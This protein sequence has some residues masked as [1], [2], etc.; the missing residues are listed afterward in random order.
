MANRLTYAD[1]GVDID[2]ANQL[3]DTIKKIAKK[4]RRT[5]V[6]GEIGGSKSFE[7]IASIKMPR[8]LDF[9]EQLPRMDNGK[10]YKRHLAEEFRGGARADDGPRVDPEA[11]KE[12]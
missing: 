7:R 12:G 1:S 8:S 2:K 6:M 9:H 11:E 5:G 10:L 4:T 3:V